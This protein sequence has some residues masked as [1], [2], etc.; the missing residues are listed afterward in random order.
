MHYLR[1]VHVCVHLIFVH[2]LTNKSRIIHYST[3]RSRFL[4]VS[5]KIL[6]IYIIHGTFFANLLHMNAFCL[7]EA[8]LAHWN[9]YCIERRD[10]AQRRY[11]A[12]APIRSCNSWQ[13]SIDAAGSYF[14]TLGE[15]IGLLYYYFYSHRVLML[16]LVQGHYFNWP[17][18]LSLLAVPG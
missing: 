3:W 5:T 10:T 9:V 18:L 13:T 16:H 17:I 15:T 6:E 7:E 1:K 14:P 11:H 4:F 12:F 2:H 8:F